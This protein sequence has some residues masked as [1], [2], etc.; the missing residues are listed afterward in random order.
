MKTIFKI[1]SIFIILLLWSSCKRGEDVVNQN[2]ASTNDA[3]D[4]SFK[5]IP[6]ELMEMFP[7][8][9]S[10]LDRSIKSDA[11]YY[12]KL[13]AS[14]NENSLRFKVITEPTS[15]APPGAPFMLELEVPLRAKGMGFQMNNSTMVHIV[16]FKEGENLFINGKDYSNYNKTTDDNKNASSNESDKSESNLDDTQN[17]YYNDLFKA[18]NTIRAKY[19][20]GTTARFNYSSEI[21]ANT[22]DFCAEYFIFGDHED[23]ESA[24]ED[25]EEYMGG[26]SADEISLN[27][28]WSNMS[29]IS[30]KEEHCR[31]MNDF[32]DYNPIEGHWRLRN[33]RMFE[34]TAKSALDS[35]TTV[36]LSEEVCMERVLTISSCTDHEVVCEGKEPDEF[37][38]FLWIPEDSSFNEEGQG[39]C[40]VCQDD[41]EYP[42][43]QGD[44]KPICVK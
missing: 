15:E 11:S 16:Y 39:Y 28:N 2:I 37:D 41:E 14:K 26:D 4:T 8:K 1:I 40:F 38:R 43:S 9:Y 19:T 18:K 30:S 17:S 23:E 6:K 10:P 44:E 35:N 3:T 36:S 20:G 25:Y 22:G 13:P 29:A 7:F 12:G 42:R 33:H 5:M 32:G 24:D 34:G 31:K 21:D 27:N